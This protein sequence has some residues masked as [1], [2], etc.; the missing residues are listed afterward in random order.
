[1]WGMKDFDEFKASREKMDPSARKMTDRQWKQAY[2]A[3]RRTRER[4]R[5]SGRRHSSE[6][7]R[8]GGGTEPARRSAREGDRRSL[9]ERVRADSAYSEVRL[10]VDLLSWI[11][12]AVIAANV[13]AVFLYITSQAAFFSVLLE[14]G[15]KAVAVVALRMLAHVVVD[16]PDITLFR[17]TAS[18]ERAPEEEAGD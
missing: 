10:A 1:M 18:A 4:R 3:Y 11:A 17:M 5:G 8:G 12:L 16:I 6:E 15:L 7:E 9:R 14:S 2:T 13:F